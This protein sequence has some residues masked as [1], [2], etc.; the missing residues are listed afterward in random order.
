MKLYFTGE[1][2][3]DRD[4]FK[5]SSTLLRPVIPS[6]NPLHASGTRKS[7]CKS[8]PDKPQQEEQEDSETG[9]VLFFCVTCSMYAATTTSDNAFFLFRSITSYQLSKTNF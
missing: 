2:E 6:A 7:F 5:L 8:R 3:G 1:G 9:D 4:S